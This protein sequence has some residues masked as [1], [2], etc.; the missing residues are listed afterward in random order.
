MRKKIETSLGYQLYKNK[1]NWE[2]NLSDLKVFKGLSILARVLGDLIIEKVENSP[3]DISVYYKINP[4]INPELLEMKL[5]AIQ[6]YA[7]SG[8]MDNIHFYQSEFHNQIRSVFGAIQRPKWG[9]MIHPEHYRTENET[10]ALI[11]PFHHIYEGNDIDYIFILEKVKMKSDPKRFFLRL[12]IE[13]HEEATY[14]LKSIPFSLVD[15][16]KY[17]V[18]IEGSTKMAESLCETLQKNTSKGLYEYSEE[19]LISTHVFEQIFKT[20]IGPLDQM[21]IF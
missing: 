21:N 6:I 7:K 4:N 10:K 8:V 9:S 3:G 2:I 19:N 12:T 16:L 1:K 13:D 18:F 17:R 14:H 20:G 5:E 11:F 15:D